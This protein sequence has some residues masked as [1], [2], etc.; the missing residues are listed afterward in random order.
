[1]AEPATPPPE[2]SRRT[3]FAE[4]RTLLAWWRTG[5]AAAAV[6]LA[7]GGIVPK[8]SGLPK[9][10]FVALGVGYGVL[11]IVFF[12][13]GTI[14]GRLSRDALERN[15]F[16]EVPEWAVITLASYMSALVVLTVIA[17]V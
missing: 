4:E 7:V 14:R 16:A 1:M 10:R 2:V 15:T 11:A 8:L 12:V 13:G 9:G 17:F 6:A 5:I 3:R